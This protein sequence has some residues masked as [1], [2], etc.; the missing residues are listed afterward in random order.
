GNAIV[1]SLYFS[2]APLIFGANSIPV[3]SITFETLPAMPLSLDV[4][5]S[6]TATV[7]VTIGAVQGAFTYSGIQR[8]F[9][10]A[11]LDS[12][13]DASEV[14][15]TF[16]LVISIGD[17]LIYETNATNPTVAFGNRN[18]SATYNQA[19]TV[20]AGSAVPLN[21]VKWKVLGAFEGIDYTFPVASL[22]FTPAT[23][24]Y[25]DGMNSKIFQAVAEVG[26][27]SAGLYVATASFY[28]DDD[29]D[30]V[31]DA[32]EASCSFN[33]SLTVNPV[34]ALDLVP[35]VVDFGQV[36]QGAAVNKEIMF[37]NSGNIQLSNFSWTFSALDKAPDQ[38][39][40]A[41][42]TYSLTF[43]PDPVLM[44]EYATSTV[45]LSV[46]AA[47]P[48][49]VYGPSGPQTI[50]TTDGTAPTDWA[51]FTCE[52]VTTGAP[53]F[54]LASGSLSQD[55]ATLSFSATA[56][57]NRYYMS[58][59]VCPGTG[60]ANISFV[61]Y[62]EFGEAVGTV[63]AQIDSAGSLTSSGAPMAVADSGILDKVP[64]EHP[65]HPG[66]DFYYYR[67]FVAFDYTYSQ[68]TASNT[69]II[70]G[71]TSNPD[72]PKNRVW[73]D[74]VQLERRRDVNQTKPSA[75]HSI[76]TIY[77]PTPKQTI[78]GEDRYNEW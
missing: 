14:S 25:I 31:I 28:D 70:L 27:V 57:D 4:G 22:T 33:L 17:K 6:V 1:N 39:L 46:D 45:T 10:D 21:R 18:V 76:R 53:T 74:G 49:G 52:I 41:N 7:T 12:T 54:Q 32:A 48:L 69:R 15:D 58:A 55:I 59:W 61:T 77:S 16:E 30:G 78:T 75:F 19:V 63:S 5:D 3:G 34:Y 42:L 35:T 73:F 56:P 2:K 24:Q 66:E 62:N 11:D 50:Q 72:A 65:D 71:N 51:S 23:A 40:P 44:G 60:S 26:F 8:M 43:T 64:Y 13:W 9:E 20:Y 47:Q 29:N 36:A 38:I 68:V 67:V 37:R